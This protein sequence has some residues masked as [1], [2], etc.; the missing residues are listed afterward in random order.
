[1]KKDMNSDYERN[2]NNAGIV[3]SF[4]DGTTFTYTLTDYLDENPG[5]TAADFRRL[6]ALSDKIYRDQID[7]NCA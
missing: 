2:A 1:M 3:Y 4:N 5:R 6:K 7:S